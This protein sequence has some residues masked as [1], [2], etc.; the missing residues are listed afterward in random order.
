MSRTRA[1]AILLTTVALLTLGAA[2]AA[3]S[4]GLT[5]KPPGGL[6]DNSGKASAP[7]AEK[8]LPYTG[9]DLPLEIAAAMSL[10]VVGGA[11]RRKPAG[12]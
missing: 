12:G 6:S 10:L 5:P 11:L 4:K 1:I 8:A 2:A 9:I 3:A 7:A